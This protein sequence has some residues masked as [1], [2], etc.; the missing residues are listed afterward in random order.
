MS[1]LVRAA[2]E[3]DIGVITALEAGSF[4]LDPWSENLVGQ[5]VRGQSPTVTFLVAESDG[6]FA[7]YAAVSV[8]DVDAELQRIAVDPDRRRGGVASALVDAV[9]TLAA[10]QGAQR[11]LLE[12]RED[13]EA[14]RA[15]YAR[16]GFGEL[17]RRQRYYRD[18]TTAV[19]LST[20]VTMDR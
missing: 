14:A 15:L 10:E 3:P 6:A 17:G 12:V 20:P 19:V 2:A 13:N 18:G 7:G 16:H 11:L 1:L 4:P 9:R 8:V 5:G